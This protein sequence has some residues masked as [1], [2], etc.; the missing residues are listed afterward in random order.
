MSPANTHHY[1]TN[2]SA[3]ICDECATMTSTKHAGYSQLFL[4]S[5]H[6][7]HFCS[8]ACMS[9]NVNTPGLPDAYRQLKIFAISLL[10]TIAALVTYILVR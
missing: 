6:I 7:R 8:S 1:L 3:R 5:G 10:V 9:A 2:T 4:H